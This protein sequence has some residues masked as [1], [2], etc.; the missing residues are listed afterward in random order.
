MALP[1]VVSGGGNGG[2]RKSSPPTERRRVGRA[3]HNFWLPPHNS[4]LFLFTGKRC[5]ERGGW[6]QKSFLSEAVV[7]P[8]ETLFTPS[9][10]K[11]AGKRRGL[12]VID[13]DKKG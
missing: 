3:I 1:P 2:R 4:L 5:R 9:A 6:G 12:G 10:E 13:V 11:G 8:E 7:S